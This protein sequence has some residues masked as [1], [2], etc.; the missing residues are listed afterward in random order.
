MNQLPTPEP[1]HVPGGRRNLA[2]YLTLPPAERQRLE[3]FAK[4]VGRP[5]SWIVRD[6]C[7]L[8]LDAMETD[9]AAMAS[10]RPVVPVLDMK[11]AGGTVQD[12]RG[13]PRKNP[14]TAA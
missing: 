7:R 11:E 12:K 14:A 13:R 5:M 8:Y 6:A 1:P 10:L 2:L 3:A 9:P 4:T